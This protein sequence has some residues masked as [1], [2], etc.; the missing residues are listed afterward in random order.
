LR[1]WISSV[2]LM[3]FGKLLQEI[4]HSSKIFFVSFLSFI[5]TCASIF[6]LRHYVVADVGC[7]WYLYDI[8]IFSLSKMRG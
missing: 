6:P 8:N 4:N 7:N 5:W 2:V 3:V 1:R